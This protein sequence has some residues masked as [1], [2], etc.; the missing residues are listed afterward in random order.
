MDEPREGAREGDHREGTCPHHGILHPH[1][2]LAAWLPASHLPHPLQS[3]GPSASDWEAS[4]PSWVRSAGGWGGGPGLAL[5][6]QVG[7]PFLSSRPLESQGCEARPSTP[8]GP[9]PRLTHRPADARQAGIHVPPPARLALGARARTRR[10]HTR[11]PG[12]APRSPRPTP[13]RSARQRPGPARAA[14][15]SREEA[16]Q[17]RAGSPPHP[18]PPIWLCPPPSGSLSPSVPLRSLPSALPPSSTFSGSPSLHP[19]PD[20]PFLFT[21]IQ[22]HSPVPH[23]E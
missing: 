6:S 22:Q 2:I 13:R 18:N 16:C 23:A 15:P 7:S 1:P 4:S 14:R 11:V 20:P 19:F 3:L 21:L 9:A 17:G 12:S 10:T 8:R 5:R